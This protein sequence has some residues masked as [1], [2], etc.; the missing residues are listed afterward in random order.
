MR[1]GGG[2]VSCEWVT[3]ITTKTG[4][5]QSVDWVSIGRFGSSIRSRFGGWMDVEGVGESHGDLC[6]RKNGKKERENSSINKLHIYI[7]CTD[8]R[9]W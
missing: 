5:T 1:W 3:I 9:G 2:S 7:I 6:D 8:Q 4:C